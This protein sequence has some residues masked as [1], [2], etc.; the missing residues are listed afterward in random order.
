MQ[1]LDDDERIVAPRV[2]TERVERVQEIGQRDVYPS[3]LRA[4][5]QVGDVDRIDLD[6]HALLLADSIGVTVAIFGRS[7]L[8]SRPAE[9]SNGAPTLTSAS[10]P[11]WFFAHLHI[12]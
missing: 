12:P 9:V 1:V 7:Y 10:R 2:G 8:I 5:E 4:S 6:R 11:P 3:E